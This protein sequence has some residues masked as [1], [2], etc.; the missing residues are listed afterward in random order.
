MSWKVSESLSK[1]R[2]EV[3]LERRGDSR[4]RREMTEWKGGPCLESRG[5]AGESD[6]SGR[7]RTLLAVVKI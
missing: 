6:C 3:N 4:Q 2:S 5:K 1:E 7:P